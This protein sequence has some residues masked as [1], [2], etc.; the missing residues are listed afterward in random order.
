[1]NAEKMLLTTRP[2]SAQYAIAELQKYDAAIRPVGELMEPGVR[3]VTLPYG[4]DKFVADA[5]GLIFARHIF[6]V[7]YS[8]ENVQ[9]TQAIL[10]EIAVPPISAGAFSVQAR[11]AVPVACIADIEAALVARGFEKNVKHPAWVVS[12]YAHPNSAGQGIVYAGASTVAQNRSRWNGGAAHY[13]KDAPISRAEYKLMEALEVFGINPVGRALDLGAAPGGWTRVLLDAGVHVTAVDPGALDAR[14]AAHPQLR[15]VCATAQ[16]FFAANPDARFDL[17]VNDMKMD[18]YESARIMLDAAP[19]LSPGGAA[20][21][22]LKLKPGQ[23][24]AKINK[25]LDL[26]AKKYRVAGT[27]QLFHNRDEVTVFLL[28]SL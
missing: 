18:M 2:E 17:I 22:T 25:A 24:L 9:E 28:P 21:M 16:R 5:P 23:G 27:R 4:W 14:L 12:L 1:M 20:V 8:G 6:P 19:F 11:G 15:Y 26:L 7:Q 13:K 3:L 10:A